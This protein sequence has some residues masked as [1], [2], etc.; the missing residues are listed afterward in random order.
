[1]SM[2]RRDHERRSSPT[3]SYVNTGPAREM[4]FD[5]LVYATDERKLEETR[6]RVTARL[7]AT[8]CLRL[9]IQ[10]GSPLLRTLLPNIRGAITTLSETNGKISRW[11]YFAISMNWTMFLL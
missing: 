8:D 4:N 7:L 1:M 6:Q 3:V 2:R 10:F 11:G 5:R 9:D